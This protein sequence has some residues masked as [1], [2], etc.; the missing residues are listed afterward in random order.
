[1]LWPDNGI[2]YDATIIDYNPTTK[3]HCVLYVDNSS[4]W[5][6]FY[7]DVSKVVWRK[8]EDQTTPFVYKTAAD[9]DVDVDVDVDEAVD[10]AV[11]VD[12]AA[13]AVV[14]A[15]PVTK[16]RKRDPY[17]AETL[18]RHPEALSIWPVK[19]DRK[20]KRPRRSLRL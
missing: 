6:N 7:D 8:C 3:E 20:C 12:E 10:A 16:K 5:V 13:D 15:P 18:Q 19:Y 14:A 9:A 2:Y 4:E 17:D 11:D 1:M